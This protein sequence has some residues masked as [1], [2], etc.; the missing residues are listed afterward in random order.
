MA[1][2]V[3]DVTSFPTIQ[4]ITNLVR[5]DIRD[6]MPGA[7]NTVGEGQIL[8]DNLTTSVTMANLFNSAVREVCRKLRIVNAPMLIADNYVMSNIPPMNGPMGRGF[9]R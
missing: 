1:N 3:V 9:R 5:S 6:D 2:V 7:T 4:T 8:I